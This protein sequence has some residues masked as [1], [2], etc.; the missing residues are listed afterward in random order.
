MKKRICKSCKKPLARGD[1][2]RPATYCSAACRQKAYRK[3]CKSPHAVP[4]R[5]L[6]SDL[7]AINDRE[8]RKR[9]A[10]DALN[11]LGYAVELTRVGAGV[12]QVGRAKRQLK[13]VESDR[14]DGG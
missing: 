8:A 3:R 1:R 5:L 11:Q 10:V 9:A 7:F 6:R 13:L 4:L 2:G 12:R 14:P